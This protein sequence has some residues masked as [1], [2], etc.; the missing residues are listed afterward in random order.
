[1]VSSILN[2]VT[3]A[4][5]NIE[6]PQQTHETKCIH[7]IRVLSAE[8]P[9]AASSGHP[10]APMGCA[11]MAHLLWSE[12]MNYSPSTP[13]WW[14]RDRFVLSNGHACALQYTMLFLTGYG[15]GME[16]LREFRQFGSD[17]PGHPENFVTKGVEVSTGPLGQGISNAVGLAIA[18]THLAATYNTPQISLFTNHTYV[19]CGDGCL[20]E[21]VSSEASSLAGHLGL[22]NLIVLYDDNKITIDGS[23]DLSFTEDVAKRY[24]A[25]G[26]HV[27]TVDSVDGDLTDL[28]EAVATAK[29]VPDKPSMIKIRTT[30]GYGSKLQG[31]AAT[32]GAPL[33]PDDMAQVKR[34]FNL[35]PKSFYV[36]PDV[37]QHYNERVTEVELVRAAWDETWTAYRS[38]EPAMAAELDRRM[39]GRITPEALDALPTFDYT[40]DGAKAGRQHS[41]ACLAALAPLLPELMGGSADL[42]PSNLTKLAC[43]GDFQKETPTGR[44]MRFGVREHGM[45][46]ICNGLFAYGGIRPFCATFLNFAGYALGSI[47]L[48]AI[49]KFGVLYIMTH[50]SIGLGEDGPTHQ[51]IEMVESLRSMPNINVF[52]PADS[53]ECTAAYRTALLKHETPTV[54]CCSRSALP[55]LEHSTV[56]GAMKGAYTIIGEDIPFADT[57]LI[58][59]GTGS[60]IGPC[61]EAAAKLWNDSGIKVRVVSMPCQDIFVEQSKT[62]QRSVLPGNIPTMSVEA[63]C[64]H[65]WHRF[66][67][68]QIGMKTFGESGK[69]A[70][71]LEHFGFTAE[72][73]AMKGKE[74]VDFYKEEGEVPDLM[75]IPEF[76]NIMGPSAH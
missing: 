11:P 64:E 26:W 34:T 25:Y 57:G 16:D 20:Q 45:A 22:G 28:R 18:Q 36:A 53:N 27:Q 69:P 65:G 31:T 60:E 15:L 73:V 14:N 51:P 56:D 43:A 35:S 1:M 63:L 23:T 40:T 10:G 4:Y 66:S 9:S 24:E 21:G 3:D 50:D 42:T 67:H 38:A 71:L 12:V 30:I 2:L 48:S 6:T 33:K 62:Y 32:H 29:T 7:T 46:A 55:K 5:Q 49:S 13:N 19:I 76:D 58:L 47:R 74:L 61:V 72:N 68:S 70:D 39:A 8:Q 17:T 52:R 54:I 44:Y 41:Q 75:L 37:Q 59:I